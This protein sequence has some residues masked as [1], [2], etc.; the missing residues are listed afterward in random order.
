MGKAARSKNTKK[1][2]RKVYF[3]HRPGQ[4]GETVEFEWKKGCEIVRKVAA[5]W[6]ERPEELF[7]YFLEGDL[8]FTP[9][10]LFSINP[11]K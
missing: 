3:K 4:I 10:G 9:L 8:C 7:E 5:K 11:I 2:K 6:S 1:E